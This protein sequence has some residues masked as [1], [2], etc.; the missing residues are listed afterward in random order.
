MIC[1]LKRLLILLLRKLEINF[2]SRKV[3][4]GKLNTCMRRFSKCNRALRLW[5]ISL[6]K[7]LI[8]RK[9]RSIGNPTTLKLKLLGSK[10]S[11]YKLKTRSFSFMN[12]LNCCF[13]TLWIWT[14]WTKMSKKT[15][16]TKNQQHLFRQNKNWP[17]GC[18]PLTTTSCPTPP[19]P[20]NPAT[21]CHP[22]SPRAPPP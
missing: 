21:P 3:C 17:A 11:Q 1:I 2:R 10:L 8:C 18:K 9:V 15:D 19:L 12:N 16:I 4:L 13:W 6:C 5:K 20:P 7:R 14:N 22:Q